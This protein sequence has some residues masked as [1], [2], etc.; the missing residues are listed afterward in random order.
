MAIS[1]KALKVL[2][3]KVAT[4]VRYVTSS[5]ISKTV[6]HNISNKFFCNKI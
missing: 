1:E 2:W 4:D 3:G 6:S 5:Y